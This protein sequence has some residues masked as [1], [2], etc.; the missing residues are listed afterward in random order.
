MI[1]LPN[2]ER[3]VEELEALSL[4]EYHQSLSD[5][6]DRPGTDQG[7][8]LLRVG[9]LV[10]V[11]LKE[12]FA[13]SRELDQPSEYSAAYREWYVPWPDEL[14]EAAKA[15]IEKTWQYSAVEILRQEE[16]QEHEYVPESAFAFAA[17]APG[18]RGFF[19]YLARSCRRYICGDPEI[20]ARLDDEMDRARKAGVDLKDPRTIVASL[21]GALG[22]ALVQAVPVLAVVGAPVIAGLVLVI[23]SVGADAFCEWAVS[24]SVDSRSAEGFND[25]IPPRPDQPGP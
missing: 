24:V 7:E 20:Q 14:D 11:V 15:D 9:R 22:I 18:E 21:G 25:P 19:A 23:Y 17:H 12:P 2:L 1:A 13:R 6:L 4:D 16:K 3:G 8:S 10:G 5:L